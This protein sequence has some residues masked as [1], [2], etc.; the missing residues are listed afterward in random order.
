MQWVKRE[1][2]TFELVGPP[3]GERLSAFTSTH[4]IYENDRRPLELA[5]FHPSQDE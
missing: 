4:P 2:G 3:A 1:E 5:H